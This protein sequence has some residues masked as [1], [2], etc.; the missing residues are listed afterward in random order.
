MLHNIDQ[1][2]SSPCNGFCEI[3]KKTNLCK[4]CFRTISEIVSWQ[5]YSDKQKLEVL[6][7]VKE[8]KEK[9]KHN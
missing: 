8:R 4:G 6:Q 5:N 2:T 7:R 1:S 9:L 3:D